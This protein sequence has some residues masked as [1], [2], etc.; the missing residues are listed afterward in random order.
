M[1][2]LMFRDVQGSE[3][4]YSQGLVFTEWRRLVGCLIFR[5]H[6]LQKSPIISGCFANN[7]LRLKA[8]YASS[9]PYIACLVQGSAK[10][11]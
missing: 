5:G 7:D 11:R 10:E 6:F 4:R 2:P 9:P 1:T 8:S 3:F